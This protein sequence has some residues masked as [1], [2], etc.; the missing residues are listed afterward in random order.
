MKERP[1]SLNDRSRYVLLLPAVLVVMFLSIF[2][3]LLSIFTSLSKI[4]FVKGGFEVTYVGLTNYRKLLQGSGQR[5][6]LGAFDDPT[7]IGWIVLAVFAASMIYW[8][9]R[10]IKGPR[11]RIFGVVVRVITIVITGGLL[12][13]MI[14]TSSGRG[15][16]GTLEVTLIFVFG[17]V[18]AQYALGLFLALLVTQN[19]PGKRFFRLFVPHAHRHPDRSSCPTV[20][21][22]RLIQFLVGE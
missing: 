18:A 6:F 7:A 15:L 5:R 17:G 3:L 20:E 19:L 11:R 2:P 21:S 12:W 1:A 9:F 16:P 10:Y 13:L 8:L 14:R 4:R 22:G